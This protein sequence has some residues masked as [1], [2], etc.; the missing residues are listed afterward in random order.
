MQN[1]GVHKVKS[2]SGMASYIT[3]KIPW[4]KTDDFKNENYMSIL[5]ILF[6]SRQEI[7]I[8]FEKFALFSSFLASLFTYWA[9]FDRKS[10]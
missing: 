1:L 7:E 5:K 4:E 2:W 9:L 10:W 6:L 3:S 8:L